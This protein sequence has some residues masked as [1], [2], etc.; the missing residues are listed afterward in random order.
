MPA[1]PDPPHDSDS[2][3]LLIMGLVALCVLYWRIALRLVAIAV[4]TVAI[5]GAVLLAEGLQH[6]GR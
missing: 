4:I 1:V 6:A 5:Y 3:G 2:I